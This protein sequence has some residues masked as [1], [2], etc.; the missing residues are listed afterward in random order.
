M[1]SATR[2][3]SVSLEALLALLSSS[4]EVLSVDTLSEA[5]HTVSSSSSSSNG[6]FEI[7]RAVR[8]LDRALQS[9]ETAMEQSEQD[10]DN[11]PIVTLDLQTDLLVVLT[12][13]AQA[14]DAVRASTTCTDW[15]NHDVV[16]LYENLAYTACR[17]LVRNHSLV[18]QNA[19][20]LDALVDRIAL[21]FLQGQDTTSTPNCLLSGLVACVNC[22]VNHVEQTSQEE[23]LV[24]FPLLQSLETIQLLQIVVPRCIQYTTRR[25][26][27]AME[28]CLELWSFCH[29]LLKHLAVIKGQNDVHGWLQH[30]FLDS[31]D[32]KHKYTLSPQILQKD[33]DAFLES[34]RNFGVELLEFALEILDQAS[35]PEVATEH[36]SDAIRHA[37]LAVCTAQVLGQGLAIP[38][39]FSMLRSL[40]VA[41]SSFCAILTHKHTEQDDTKK[42]ACGVLVE[43]A[44]LVISNPQSRSAVDS[45]LDTCVSITLLCALDSNEIQQDFELILEYMRGKDSRSSEPPALKRLKREGPFSHILQSTIMASLMLPNTLTPSDSLARLVQSCP[46]NDSNPW[47]PLIARKVA[48]SFGIDPKQN[49][50][51]SDN[52]ET[53]NRS[54]S[55]KVLRKYVSD[56]QK[57]IQESQVATGRVTTQSQ[58]R[59][60]IEN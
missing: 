56:H 45:T 30:E 24:L 59:S 40:F 19:H 39:S 46:P 47:H 20:E 52:D 4:S 5:A 13:L 25:W 60:N 15:R 41:Y 43:M 32:S 28:D 48:E 3:V 50:R 27:P 17:I 11:E 12:S 57:P 54:W 26:N 16:K 44:L 14:L 1:E 31:Q 42:V 10:H 23:P 7:R 51:N 35:I 36:A 34:C 6:G 22:H 33:V 55:D 29:T 2:E 9:L 58:S 53:S 37:S 18:L 38:V 8:R 49:F 21:L